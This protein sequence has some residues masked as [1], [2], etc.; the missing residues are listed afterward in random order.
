MSKPGLNVYCYQAADICLAVSSHDLTLP[1][2]EP[3]EA[4]SIIMTTDTNQSANMFHSTYVGSVT[5]SIQRFKLWLPD[6]CCNGHWC[7]FFLLMVFVQCLLLMCAG[8]VHRALRWWLWSPTI[9]VHDWLRLYVTK[10]NISRGIHYVCNYYITRS[11]TLVCFQ[12]WS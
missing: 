9:Y 7:V 8:M 5:N 4:Q 1:R 10:V 11:V 3:P 2:R 6:N 12:V